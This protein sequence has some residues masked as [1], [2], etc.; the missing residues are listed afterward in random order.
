MENEKTETGP[1]HSGAP[2]SPQPAGTSQVTARPDGNALLQQAIAHHHKGHIPEAAKFY[3]SA[4]KIDPSLA[5]AWINL[6]VLLRRDNKLESAVMCMRRGLQL[7]PDDGSSWSNLGNA[8]RALNRLDEAQEAQNRALAL[9][10]EA[11]Q[12]HYNC[13]LIQRDRGCLDD[14]LHSFRRAE[15][16]GYGKPE[17]EWD[18]SLTLLLKGE[19]E[20]GFEAYEARWQLPES[21]PRH[22]S[23]PIWKGAKLEGQTLLVSAEQG[24]GDSLQFCRYLPMIKDLAD[25]VVFE[26]QPPLARL[27]RNSPEMEGIEIL[28]RDET[29]PVAALE[30]QIDMDAVI[31]LLS[32]PRILKTGT[33]NLPDKVPYL[34]APTEDAPRLKPRTD[35]IARVG[36]VWAGKP[37]HK[38]D[39]NRSV[40]LERFSTLL[41]MP[42]VR[43][44]SFQKGGPEGR[45]EQLGLEPIIQDLSPHLRDFADTAA[46]LEDMDLLISVDTSVAHM[47][48][49]L[50]RPVWVLL[51]Y[52]PDWRWQIWRDDSPWY[53]SMTLFR[54]TSPGDW[55]EV[56]QRVRTA[57]RQFIQ[58][59][60]D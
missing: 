11:A 13:A 57:L 7:S 50:A 8:L 51:P 29:Q 19:L 26:C 21:P 55:T 9:N 45:I 6:G 33:D 38:N 25:R 53:P 12:I 28:E 1:A 40:G 49:A 43:F 24:M 54:Q 14:A 16:L 46:L 36:L 17:L 42:N 4:L 5:P 20:E 39:R 60:L 47:A 34:H 31:P 41:E 18:R 37:S 56:F 58:E 48:G 3:R 23:V 30:K 22:P 44:F 27:L 15:M 59:N 35:G 2:E 10:P 32:L 52:A